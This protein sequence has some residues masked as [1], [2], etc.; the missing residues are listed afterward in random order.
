MSKKTGVA[1]MHCGKRTDGSLWHMSKKRGELTLCKSCHDFW[2]EA[3]IELADLL[4]GIG[5]TIGDQGCNVQTNARIVVS[6]LNAVCNIL[7]THQGMVKIVARDLVGQVQG[8]HAR[9]IELE[10]GEE[11]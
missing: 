5:E 1:C 6:R 4:A 7:G 11:Q 9:I 2:D 3:R 8:L 10:H